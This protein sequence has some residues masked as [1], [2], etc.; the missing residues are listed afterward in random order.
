MPPKITPPRQNPPAHSTQPPMPMTQRAKTA[1]TGA[2]L[3][4]FLPKP[5]SGKHEKLSVLQSLE[6]G[7]SSDKLGLQAAIDPYKNSS[8]TEFGADA[9]I[10]GYLQERINEVE[11]GTDML[12]RDPVRNTER[13]TADPTEADVTQNRNAVVFHDSELDDL[14]NVFQMMALDRDMQEEPLDRSQNRDAI[15]FK[16]SELQDL[17]VEF[18]MMELDE[19][20][21]KGP[22]ERA[23]NRSGA[24]LTAADIQALDT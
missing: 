5:G 10:F 16:A 2:G 21:K 3:A 24:Q 14:D 1:K 11:L 22:S 6:G 9:G 23:M 15:E 18:K 19:E 4:G 7:K 20:L 8:A 17:E 12:V 13:E